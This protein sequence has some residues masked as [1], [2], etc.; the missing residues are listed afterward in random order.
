ML[1]VPGDNH[2]SGL[3]GD[4]RQDR[5]FG[6]TGRCIVGSA[7]CFAPFRQILQACAGLA[8]FAAFSD[9]L[10]IDP[11]QTPTLDLKGVLF[12]ATLWGS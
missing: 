9:E 11:D 10:L 1:V 4:A 5:T 6:A 3:R 8:A 2:T 12:S 7:H